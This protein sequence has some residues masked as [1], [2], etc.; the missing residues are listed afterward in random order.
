MIEIPCS[1]D[2]IACSIEQTPDGPCIVF[3]PCGFRSYH[4]KDIEEEYCARCHRWMDLLR[5]ARAIRAK[6]FP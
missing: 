5:A 2:E 4:P 1:P 3:S 6:F